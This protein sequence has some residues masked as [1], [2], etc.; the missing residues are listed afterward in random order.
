MRTIVT[1]FVLFWVS[2]GIV[3]SGFAFRYGTAKVTFKVL[4]EQ[5]RPIEGATISGG[6]AEQDK[7]VNARRGFSS[8]TDAEG[9]F[10]VSGRTHGE[11]GYSAEKK[12]ITRQVED[13]ANGLENN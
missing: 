1:I 6:F 8:I 2:F 4:D 3:E 7:G 13:T 12:V 9:E 5:N 11:I 10:F